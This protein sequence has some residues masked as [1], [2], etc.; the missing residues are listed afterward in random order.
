MSSRE[1]ARALL[2][3]ILRSVSRSFYISI[4]LL[5]RKLRK[6]VGLAYLLARATDT[7]ADTVEVPALVRAETLSQLLSIIE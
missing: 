7:V 6:P 3:P 2:G 5:P 4:R 1:S